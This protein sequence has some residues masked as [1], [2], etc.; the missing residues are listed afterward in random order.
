MLPPNH[1]AWPEVA[2]SVR[3][4]RIN[5]SLCIS[6]AENEPMHSCSCANFGDF[7]DLLL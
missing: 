4:L 6:I 1:K 7:A 5:G 2:F 3:K